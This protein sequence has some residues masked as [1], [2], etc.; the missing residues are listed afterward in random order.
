[1]FLIRSVLGWG[2]GRYKRRKHKFRV[3]QDFRKMK[4]TTSQI[5]TSYFAF[6]TREDISALTIQRAWVSHLN[7]TTFRLLKQTICA[8]EHCVTHEI[9]KKVSPLEADLVKDPSM[10]CKV[11]FRFGGETFPPFIVFKIFLHTEGRGYKYFSGKNMLK[12]SSK[13]AVDAYTIMGRKKFHDQIMEDEHLF[14]KFKITDELDIVTRKDY[15]QVRN[16]DLDIENK[17]KTTTR[18][19]FDPR[20]IYFLLQNIHNIK[21]TI[22]KCT[23]QWHLVHSQRCANITTI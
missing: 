2:M 12:P 7:K 8:A 6:R 21:F 13:A 15:I 22:L 5:L 19:P 18:K 17:Q 16:L 20:I 10:K 9:V 1:M 23:I 11:K 14:R 4:T 3:P